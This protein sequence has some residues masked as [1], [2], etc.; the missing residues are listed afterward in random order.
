MQVALIADIHANAVALD[1]VLADLEQEHADQL[2]CLG[3]LVGGGPQPRE[4]IA[5]I[6]G[7]G[8]PVVTGNV[9]VLVATFAPEAAA[10]LIAYFVQH[11]ASEESARRMVEINAWF[12]AQLT[13]AERSFLLDLQPTVTISL[14]EAA[15][16]LCFHGSPR[17]YED[18]I[19]A[20]TPEAELAAVFD[21]SEA[22]VLAGGHTHLALL[23][24][25]G[26]RTLVNPGTV[27][28]MR[29]AD[30]RAGRKLALAEYALV[31]WEE[32]RLGVDFRRIPFD[33]GALDAAA[34]ASGMPHAKWFMQAYTL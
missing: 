14:G 10:P 17:S 16:L 6:R 1:A 33:I 13:P 15:T 32:G 9:D 19:V 26:L 31:S 12:A 7:L 21:G 2:V 30:V 27:G 3:D 5:R 28:V 24:R 23:R 34:H 20:T 11:G 4:V 8:C 22:T 18:V 25:F 29:A